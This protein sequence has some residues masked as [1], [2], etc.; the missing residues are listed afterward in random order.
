MQN[1]IYF[2]N[3]QLN[4]GRGERCETSLNPLGNAFLLTVP[5]RCFFCGSFLLFVFRV[6]RVFLSVHRSFSPAGK[7]LTSWLSCV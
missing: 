3:P 2:F 6:C 4:Q 7:G 1:N 5:R